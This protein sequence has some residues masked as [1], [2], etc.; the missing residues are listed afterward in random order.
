MQSQWTLVEEHGSE[1]ILQSQTTARYFRYRIPS[2]GCNA[3]V[4]RQ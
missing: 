2:P 4:P 1:Q 3:I